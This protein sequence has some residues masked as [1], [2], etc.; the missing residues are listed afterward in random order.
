MSAAIQNNDTKQTAF[1]LYADDCVL[2]WGLKGLAPQ[3]HQTP[4][5]DGAAKLQFLDSCTV[6][7]SQE[8]AERARRQLLLPLIA[9]P[10]I[11]DCR[12]IYLSKNYRLKMQYAGI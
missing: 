6:R 8:R 4:K 10:C 1:R 12:N 2:K 7:S 9:A 5:R 3:S 11:F